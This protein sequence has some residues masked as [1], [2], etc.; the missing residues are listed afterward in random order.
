MSIF[1][2]RERKNALNR[3]FRPVAFLSVLVLMSPLPTRR[4]TLGHGTIIAMQ[5]KKD[6]FI[7]IAD[8]R[9]SNSILNVHTD[10]SCKVMALADN[11]FVFTTGIA[12]VVLPDGTIVD[13]TDVIKRGFAKTSTLAPHT[14]MKLNNIASNIAI[15]LKNFIQSLLL[16]HPKAFVGYT[17]EDG[18]VAQAV[19]GE[20]TTDGQLV[21]DIVRIKLDQTV[22]TPAVF[23]E[24]LRFPD[25]FDLC[26][27]GSP[28]KRGIGE[29]WQNQSVRSKEANARMQKSI[30]KIQSP[31]IDLIKLRFAVQSAIDW[32]DNP[33]VIGGPLDILELKAG[34]KIHWI[35]RKKN[36]KD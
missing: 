21:A 5:K 19:I 32:S 31:D 4:V 18:I 7:V 30:S 2:K 17:F 25:G 15:E 11:I 29:F 33:N 13:V 28:Q 10:D 8:S 6:R 35:Q 27:L 20:A 3:S 1:L 12:H 36:C 24:S 9:V 14:E 23:P 16:Q 34:G 26:V 22:K